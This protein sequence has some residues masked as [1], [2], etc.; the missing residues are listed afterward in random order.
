[1]SRFYNKI[2]TEIVTTCDCY[3][4]NKILNCEVEAQS[5]NAYEYKV[6]LKTTKTLNS[7]SNVTKWNNVDKENIPILLYATLGYN[8]CTKINKTYFILH[9]N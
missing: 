3:F 9:Y 2:S 8:Y 4:N 1:L 5:N 6:S 7:D